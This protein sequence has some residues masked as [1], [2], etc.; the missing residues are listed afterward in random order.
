ML[1][2]HHHC[3]IVK[4]WN[5]IK[6]LFLTM[7]VVLVVLFLIFAIIL[8]GGLVLILIPVLVF[9]GILLGIKQYFDEMDED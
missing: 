4:M 2:K 1:V 7:G 5:F 6:A 3:L 9:L 8:S